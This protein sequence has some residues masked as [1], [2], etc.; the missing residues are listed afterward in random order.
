MMNLTSREHIL[1]STVIRWRSW[2]DLN[3]GLLHEPDVLP[4]G[5]ELVIPAR[6]A[7]APIDSRMLPQSYVPRAVAIHSRHGN[8][9]VP[10]RPV[11]SHSALTPRARLASPRLAN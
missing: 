1:S 3:R 5:L 4:I 7:S 10:V 6:A 9:L 11:P 2:L 8:R